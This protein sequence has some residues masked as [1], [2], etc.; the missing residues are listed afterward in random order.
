MEAAQTE[1]QRGRTE[2]WQSGREAEGRNAEKQNSI[3]EQIY[4]ERYK[5]A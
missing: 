1:R 3:E 5:G 2:E 4:A